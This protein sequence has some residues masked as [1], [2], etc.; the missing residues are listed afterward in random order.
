MG[1]GIA[2]AAGLVDG[3]VEQRRDARAGS[4]GTRRVGTGWWWSFAETFVAGHASF[5]GPLVAGAALVLAGHGGPGLQD[6]FGV[7]P[8]PVRHVRRDPDSQVREG[9]A[10][11]GRV[12]EETSE[13]LRRG[14]LGLVVGVRI[15]HLGHELQDELVVVFHEGAQLLLSPQVLRQ[16]R[17]QLLREAGRQDGCGGAA[18]DGRLLQKSGWQGEA[19]EVQTQRG[20]R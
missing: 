16:L 8:G 14:G 6:R 15:A 17:L 11:P 9:V 3:A 2:Q 1:K 5:A 20:V 18:R 4:D 13:D 10:C 7:V 12:T 19:Q